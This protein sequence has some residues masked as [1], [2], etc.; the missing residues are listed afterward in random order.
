M[1]KRGTTQDISYRNPTM[2]QAIITDNLLS[3][4]GAVPIFIPMHA[5]RN[6]QGSMETYPHSLL[7][8]TSIKKH[9]DIT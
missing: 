7:V 9:L 1:K 2:I 8:Q 5:V 4:I 3:Q 6:K